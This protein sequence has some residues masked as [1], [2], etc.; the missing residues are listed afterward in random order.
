MVIGC[1][2]RARAIKGED[3]EIVRRKKKKPI[4][5]GSK[6]KINHNGTSVSDQSARIE[7]RKS[8]TMSRRL[9]FLIVAGLALSGCCLNGSGCYIP[10]PNSALT[11]WDG[12]GPYPKRNHVKR[13]KVRTTNE[14]VVSDDN[15]PSEEELSKLRP[16]SEE[17]GAVFEA[18]NRAADSKLKKKL[19]ICRDCLPPEPDDQT[20]SITSNGTAGYLPSRR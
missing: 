10:P 20:G 8:W 15:S 3:P 5:F 11:S 14:A 18:I 1:G 17:W 6:E 13:L 2:L 19:I 12:L 16:Y 9:A 4:W 7:I